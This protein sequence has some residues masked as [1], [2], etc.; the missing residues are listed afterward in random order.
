MRVRDYFPPSAWPPLTDGLTFYAPLTRDHGTVPIYSAGGS[1]GLSTE[2]VDGDGTYIDAYSGYIVGA[3]ANTGRVGE[4]GLVSEV[5]SINNFVQ[6]DLFSDA[7]WSTTRG[8]ITSGQDTGPDN[9][10]S[11]WLLTRT[12]T[13]NRHLIQSF[14][15]DGGA[16]ALTAIV[17]KDTTDTVILT[18]NDTAIQRTFT[19][20]TE[21]FSGATGTATTSFK[22]RANGYYEISMMYTGH[23]DAKTHGVITPDT[24]GAKVLVYAQRLEKKTA[25]TSHIPTGAA[26]VTR[27]ADGLR[28]AGGANV[29]FTAGTAIWVTTIDA[30]VAQ[31]R[32]C[33]E[34]G[35]GATDRLTMLIDTNSK[36]NFSIV[37]GTVG[38][39]S[40][41]AT[42]ALSAGTPAVIAVAWATN[43]VRMY[44]NGGDEKTD[45]DTATMPSGTIT[46]DMGYLA[47]A[48]GLN[49]NGANE[50]FMIFDRALSAA[51]ILQVT[52]WIQGR[53]GLL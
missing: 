36:P 47:R 23:A 15:A 25:P 17:K 28:Y 3:S 35:A 11:G 50:H 18:G 2:T 33:W 10:T 8:A 49:L 43:D 24:A 52:Q 27:S 45:P 26:A 31:T 13:T 19:F 38:Q 6:D 21:E 20:S 51:E 5:A 48:A 9:T 42:S 1:T 4:N 7:A 39:A 44:V 37:D 46:I 41:T 34:I 12:D 29:S 40:L 53:V 30:V 14:D 22:T 32:V 16:L